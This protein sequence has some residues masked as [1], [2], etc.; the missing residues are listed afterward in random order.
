MKTYNM[1]SELQSVFPSDSII[2]ELEASEIHGP[3]FRMLDLPRELRNLIYEYALV[4]PSLM[5]LADFQY[6]GNKKHGYRLM[7]IS[8]ATSRSLKGVSPALLRTNVQIG[9]EATETFYG[10]NKFVF[11]SEREWYPAVKWLQFIG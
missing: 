7:P 4:S 2:Q 1:E 6:R 8:A 3:A 9:R 10:K 11:R 5:H